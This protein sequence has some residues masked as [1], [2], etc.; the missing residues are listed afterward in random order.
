MILIALS[1]FANTYQLNS[2]HIGHAIMG[3]FKM[4]YDT[5]F[6]QDIGAWNVGSVEDLS[7]VSSELT[8][9]AYA[10]RA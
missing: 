10:L 4:F 9:C 2:V 3:C 8:I 1:F 5:N 6:N 7:G